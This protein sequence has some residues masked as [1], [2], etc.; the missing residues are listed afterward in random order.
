MEH[1]NLN[2]QVSFINMFEQMSSFCASDI[3]DPTCTYTRHKTQL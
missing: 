3:F 1:G 2:A